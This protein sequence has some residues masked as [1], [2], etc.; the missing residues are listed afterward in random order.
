M[1]G[2]EP[3]LHTCYPGPVPTEL[4]VLSCSCGGVLWQ[5]LGG[6]DGRTE[7]KRPKLGCTGLR[8]SNGLWQ[9]LCSETATLIPTL[10]VVASASSC[11]CKGHGWTRTCC[12]VS[13][14]QGHHGGIFGARCWDLPIKGEG[15]HQ[16]SGTLAGS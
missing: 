12:G 8:S 15:L 9:S 6:T 2:W 10:P 4:Q 16:G 3:K 5:S 14:G 7:C 1:Q 13:W 11:I